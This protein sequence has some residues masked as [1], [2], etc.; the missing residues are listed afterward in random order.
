MRCAR[1][2]PTQR[3]PLGIKNSNDKK[4]NKKPSK[5][6]VGG[7]KRSVIWNTLKDPGDD[8]GWEQASEL[9]LV[10]LLFSLRHKEASSEGLA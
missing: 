10:F 6:A 4:E 3:L 8:V 2:P 7:G 5:R 9:F 1:S